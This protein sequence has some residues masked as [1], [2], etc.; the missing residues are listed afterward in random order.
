M[1]YLCVENNQRWFKSTIMCGSH[2]FECD[3]EGYFG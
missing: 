1:V 3:S 2:V